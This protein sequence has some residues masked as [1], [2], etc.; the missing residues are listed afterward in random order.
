MKRKNKGPA[1]IVKNGKRVPAREQGKPRVKK[2]GKRKPIIP[3]DGREKHAQARL[4][5]SELTW[6]RL[7]SL[8][9]N[10]KAHEAKAKEHAKTEKEAADEYKLPNLTKHQYEVL[11]RREKEAKI[12]KNDCHRTCK[13]IVVEMLSLI[14]GAKKG[15]FLPF[16]GRKKDGDDLDRKSVV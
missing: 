2:E 3:P 4:D 13:R 7:F 9:D 1:T 8:S 12:A 16:K 10:W 11:A 14:D 6:E 5:K 15:E